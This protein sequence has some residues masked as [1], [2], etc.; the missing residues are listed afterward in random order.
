MIRAILTLA[1]VVAASYFGLGVYQ[2]Y[3][4]CRD[5]QYA[6]HQLLWSPACHDPMLKPVYGQK[7][8]A[9]C[10]Q[11]RLENRMHPVVCALGASW[12][13]G[14]VMRIWSMMTESSWIM[15]GLA[16]VTIWVAVQAM[17]TAWDRNA[18]RQMMERV[19]GARVSAALP[20]VPPRQSI[21]YESRSREPEFLKRGY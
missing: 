14:E 13:G 1:T 4:K 10:E 6:N 20:Y 7:Q 12:R 11:A 2:E 17:L 21:G 16:A 5:T 15:F 8:A 9:V 3:H 19:V 18:N